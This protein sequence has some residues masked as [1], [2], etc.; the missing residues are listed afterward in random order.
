[1]PNGAVVPVARFKKNATEE[2]FVQWS[3]FN[4][5]RYLDVRVYA[6]D[7]AE[8]KPTKK[9]L[10]LRADLWREVLPAVIGEVE[11]ARP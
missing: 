8:P 10:C 6:T 1:M 2:V 5:G 4:G 11:E 9:G 7:G 3:D